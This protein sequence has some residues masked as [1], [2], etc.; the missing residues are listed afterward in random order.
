MLP[1]PTDLVESVLALDLPL[2]Q[3]RQRVVDDF[4]RRYVERVLVKHGGSVV[5]AAAASGIARRYFQ[6]LRARTR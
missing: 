1:T 3:A 4:E 5:K 6:I 2:S